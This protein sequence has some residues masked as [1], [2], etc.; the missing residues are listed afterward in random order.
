MSDKSKRILYIEDNELNRLLVRRLLEHA[1]FEVFEAGDGL[2]GVKSAEELKPDLIL[3]DINLPIM[4]GF[5]ATRQ[6]KANPELKHIP[7]VA[8]TSNAMQGDRERTLAAGCDAY[9]CKPI[10]PDA[11][12]EQIAH[13]IKVFS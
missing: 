1:G 11:F 2:K 6:I 10:D 12:P 8:I 4:D 7:I 3:M 9:I 13:F 5:E